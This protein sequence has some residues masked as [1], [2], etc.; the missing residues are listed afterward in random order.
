MVLTD[1]QTDEKIEKPKD[2]KLNS[3]RENTKNTYYAEIIN[4]NNT[5]NKVYI[6]KNK[7]KIEYNRWYYLLE[8]KGWIYSV[9][10][11]KI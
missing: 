10:C 2:F 4:T 3:V 11:E 7:V 5:I 6:E 9:F 8:M 1:F